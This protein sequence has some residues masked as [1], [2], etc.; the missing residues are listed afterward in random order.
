MMLPSA[1]RRFIEEREAPKVEKMVDGY[2]GFLFLDE[3]GMPLVAMHW[4]H[5]LTHMVKRYNEIFR[6]QIPPSPTP[7]VA[8]SKSMKKP[9]TDSHVSLRLW[10]F[11]YSI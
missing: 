11:Q 10:N 3:D 2:S 1:S 7:A 8:G 4:E 5:R 6:E 9:E